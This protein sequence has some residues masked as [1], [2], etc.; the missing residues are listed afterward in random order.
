MEIEG[1]DDDYDELQG[2]SDELIAMVRTVLI[3]MLQINSSPYADINFCPWEP[4][5]N[6]RPL[7]TMPSSPPP[8]PRIQPA[9]VNNE[10]G[11]TQPDGSFNRSRSPSPNIELPSSVIAPT[12]ALGP[13]Y[14]PPVDASKSTSPAHGYGSA[15]TEEEVGDRNRRQVGDSTPSSQRPQKRAAPEDGIIPNRTPASIRW[16]SANNGW[17]QRVSAEH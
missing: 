1:E 4:G 3:D 9:L 17:S 11:D 6:L 7:I 12:T 10:Y 5:L 16:A 14:Y 8:S 13:P 2:P 15:E